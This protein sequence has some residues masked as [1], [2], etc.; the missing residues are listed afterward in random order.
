MSEIGGSDFGGGLKGLEQELDRIS[1]LPPS[2][3]R[4]MKMKEILGQLLS[5]DRFSIKCSHLFNPSH[6]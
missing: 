1:T 4:D 5:F 2:G 6:F 3:P